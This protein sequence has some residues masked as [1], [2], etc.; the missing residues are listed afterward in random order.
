MSSVIHVLIS[1][2]TEFQVFFYL[3]DVFDPVTYGAA[4]SRIRLLVRVWRVAGLF[5]IFSFVFPCIYVTAKGQT[6]SVD[7]RSIVLVEVF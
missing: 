4:H 3:Y 7:L 1:C 2:S 5:R 6:C